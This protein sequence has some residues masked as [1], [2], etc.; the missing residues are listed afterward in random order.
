MISFLVAKLF[1]LLFI[2]LFVAILLTWV[3]NIDWYKQPFKF[4][5]ELSELFFAPFRRI[6][7]PIGGLDF[8]PIIAF[9]FLRFVSQTI[10]KFL[11]YLNL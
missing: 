1:D 8:S 2:F 5:R 3:P 6:I 11:I 4:L 7:P 9:I 10:V